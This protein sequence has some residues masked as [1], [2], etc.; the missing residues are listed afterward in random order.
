[1]KA[2]KTVLA[3]HFV[4]DDGT[5]RDGIK[6]KIGQ[7]YKVEG[8]IVPCQRGLH[9]SVRP[10]DAL[11]FAPGLILRRTE[12][13]GTIVEHN[14]DKIASSERRALWQIDATKLLHLFACWAAENALKDAKVTDER[15]WKAIKIKRQWL[16]KK[17]TDEELAAAWDAASAAARDARA[18]AS[19]AAWDAAR[20]AAWDAAWAS[21]DPATDAAWDAAWAAWDAASDAARDAAWAARAAAWAASAASSAASAARA[22]AS[23]AASAAAWAA[24]WAAWDAARDAAWEKMNKKL[25]A[26]AMAAGR[27][28]RGE[29]K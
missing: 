27:S 9:G 6:E 15:C 10:L 12:H 11:E 3:W 24:A 13:R 19:A 26:M 23:D 7:W 29:K 28:K 21:W 16:G 14:D 18:A 25:T 8:E 2:Q 17:A 4:K 20:D 5:N 1:M 22:A